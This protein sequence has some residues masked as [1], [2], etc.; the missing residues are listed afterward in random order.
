MIA[1]LD[2]HHATAALPGTAPVAMQRGRHSDRV[3]LAKLRAQRRWLVRHRDKAGLALDHPPHVADD[4][5][6]ASGRI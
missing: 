6:V 1:Q 3:A 5:R 4:G 2:S